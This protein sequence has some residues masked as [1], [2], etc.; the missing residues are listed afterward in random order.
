MFGQWPVGGVVDF[1]VGAGAVVLAG[2][3]LVVVAADAP[4]IPTATPPAASVPVMI[5][6]LSSLEVRIG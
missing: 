5:A 3:E 2:V 6:A 1:G 4:A